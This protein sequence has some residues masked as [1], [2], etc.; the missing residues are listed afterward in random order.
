[1]IR[2]GQPDY[3]PCE[4][5]GFIGHGNDLAP[6]TAKGIAQAKEAARNPLL[7]G[8]QLIV[9][10]PYTRALQTAAYVARETG[11]NIV[12]EVD[13]REWTPDLTYQFSTPE[14][15]CVAADEYMLRNGV[16]AWD[17]QPPWENAADMFRRAVKCLAPYS[18]KYDK[19]VVVGHSMVMQQFIPFA[20]IRFCS[21]WQVPLPEKMP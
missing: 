6:L 18:E 11:L 20:R 3:K 5:R 1:M 4:T 15:A 7:A 16:C 2:H 21:V 13:L 19:I 12:V 10:S 14:E 8:T 9:S 17:R